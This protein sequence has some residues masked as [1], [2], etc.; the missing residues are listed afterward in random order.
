MPSIRYLRLNPLLMLPHLP[1]TR[2]LRPSITPTTTAVTLRSRIECSESFNNGW[3][4]RPHP[5]AVHNSDPPPS[6]D[7]GQSKAQE[8]IGCLTKDGVRQGKNK[9]EGESPEGQGSIGGY[10]GGYSS[11]R[12][13]GGSYGGGSTQQSR[14]AISFEV[15]G[16]FKLIV[17]AGYGGGGYQQSKS[18][19]S[20]SKP[21]DWYP[22]R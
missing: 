22:R 19:Y 10:S 18:G 12:Q 13:T 9:H 21:M 11:G 4:S 6:A 16:Q 15:M 7:M 20:G 3:V 1:F 8:T 14:T 2:Y 17:F 5:Y